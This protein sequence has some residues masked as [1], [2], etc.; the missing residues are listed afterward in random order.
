MIRPIHDRAYT[1]YQAV[2]YTVPQ[3]MRYLCE[4]ALLY[5]SSGTP[6]SPSSYE[7]ASR[8]TIE[9]VENPSTVASV[10]SS[11]HILLSSKP[12]SCSLKSS[13]YSFKD[14]HTERKMD[15]SL[16]GSECNSEGIDFEILGEREGGSSSLFEDSDA[17]T[18]GSDA[19]SSDGGEPDVDVTVA[20]EEQ[21]VVPAA[22]KRRLKPEEIR[23]RGSGDREGYFIRIDSES[24]KEDEYDF[25]SFPWVEELVARTKSIYTDE[26]TI[27]AFVDSRD[28]VDGNLPGNVECTW[29]MEDDRVCSRVSSDD[30]R[31]F[32]FARPLGLIPI[33]SQRKRKILIAYAQSFKHFKDHFFRL[34]SEEGVDSAALTKEEAIEVKFLKDLPPLRCIK[35]IRFG[36]DPVKLKAFMDQMAPKLDKKALM[37]E[38]KRQRLASA[39]K[40]KIG[41]SSSTAAPELPNIGGIQ[42]L[43]PTSSVGGGRKRGWTEQTP[44]TLAG[45]ATAEKGANPEEGLVDTF[46]SFTGSSTDIRSLWDTRFDFG[47]IIDENLTLRSDVRRLDK[48]GDRSAHV[49][50]QVFG[51]QTTFLGRYLELK[52]K[53]EK[54]KHSGLNDK[55]TELEAKLLGYEEMKMKIAGIE[56]RVALLGQENTK[57]KEDKSTTEQGLADMTTER[58]S[59]KSAEEKYATDFRKLNSDA[60]H[61]YRLGFEQALIQIK[62]FNPEAD[63]SGCDPMKEV[64]NNALVDLGEGDEDPGS[65]DPDNEEEIGDSQGGRSISL[66]GSQTKRVMKNRGMPL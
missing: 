27:I 12:F 23:T 29:M 63:T 50:L 66:P 53:N 65:A 11:L 42:T 52:A 60:A 41:A 16:V 32:V 58:D 48:K 44:P 8:S 28:V 51:A 39:N 20:D 2:R 17:V 14:S 55:V 56:G 19:E 33:N 38:M 6:H 26:K 59:L 7:V 64:V 4:I 3:A 57:L 25:V 30:C 10:P 5:V 54:T 46:Q 15:S 45:Q 62:H 61:S 34:N 18:G 43:E 35:L 36:D 24:K 13:A 22:K 1:V 31:P 40:E 37:L 49:M 21:V 9:A 47:S